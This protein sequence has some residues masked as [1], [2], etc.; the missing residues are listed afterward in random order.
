MWPS[1]N[2]KGLRPRGGES[3]A[4]AAAVLGEGKG[5]SVA[6]AG[7][8]GCWSGRALG[9]EGQK[10]IF[11][12]LTLP[13]GHSRALVPARVPLH[14]LDLLVWQKQGQV[15]SGRSHSRHPQS[16]RPSVG[17]TTWE[18]SPLRLSLADFSSAP[19]LPRPLL[20]T[21]QTPLPAVSLPRRDAGGVEP[22]PLGLW[23]AKQRG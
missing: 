6:H 22:S 1:G 21:S 4:G 19:V 5:F 2:A 9:C 3:G 11:E 17:D 7:K 14:G 8:R 16:S 18:V 12:H 10:G 20:A 15:P 23:S 13:A